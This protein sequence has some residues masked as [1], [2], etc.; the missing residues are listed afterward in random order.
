MPSAIAYPT[1][2]VLSYAETMAS[3]LFGAA[4][5]TRNAPSRLVVPGIDKSSKMISTEPFEARISSAQSLGVGKGRS[6]DAD[7]GVA[8]Q[9]VVLDDKQPHCICL[10]WR[11][12]AV[13][14]SRHSAASSGQRNSF[15]TIGTLS[16]GWNEAYSGANGPPVG[17][18]HR[19]GVSAA[20][21]GHETSQ[22]SAGAWE[23]ACQPPSSRGPFPF[24]PCALA[25]SWQRQGNPPNFDNR[26]VAA[27]KSELTQNL[28]HVSLYGR[29][30]QLEFRGNL[31]ILQA[32][33]D[34]VQHA[35][36]LRR[37]LLDFLS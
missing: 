18:G 32:V 4:A 3:A 8:K 5:R 30:R 22:T 19:P 12:H 33:P 7:Q 26:L 28:G 23:A 37:Q 9:R 36:L 6:N 34:Q 15:V 10:A 27:E 1:I 11:R 20:A 17:A 25:G 14:R 21:P 2:R 16:Q 24:A 13:G 31:A 35:N 29:L